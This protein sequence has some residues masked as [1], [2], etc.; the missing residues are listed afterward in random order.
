MDVLLEL[1]ALALAHW[2]AS[3]LMLS[4]LPMLSL[5]VRPHLLARENPKKTKEIS[6]YLT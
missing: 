3:F 5:I 4:S 1:K 6:V 2:N